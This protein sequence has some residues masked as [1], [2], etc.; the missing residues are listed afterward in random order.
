MTARL[1]PN[2]LT[3]WRRHVRDNRD[4]EYDTTL[5]DQLVAKLMAEVETLWAERDRTRAEMLAQTAA[6]LED[7]LRDLG[8]RGP[9]N[10]PG[11][12]CVYCR[13]ATAHSFI[14]HLRDV[15]AAAKPRG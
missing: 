15:A 8:R 11:Y 2:A 6:M 14:S 9:P 12:G 10:A 5:A 3:V 13:D 4:D 7:R 1:T